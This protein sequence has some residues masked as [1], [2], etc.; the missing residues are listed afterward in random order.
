MKYCVYLLLI[1]SLAVSQ[2][3]SLSSSGGD[4]L[5]ESPFYKIPA[6]MTFEEYRDANRRISVGMMMASIPVPGM[7]HFYADENTKGWI[8][9]GAAGLGVASMI[10]GVLL[11]GDEKWPETDYEVE[12]ID[13]LRY[14]KIPV[15]MEGEQIDYQLKRMEMKEEMSTGGIVLIGFGGVLIAGQLI[16]DWLDGVSTI[17][18]KRDAVRYKYGFGERDAM[19]SPTFGVDD[20][21][22]LALRID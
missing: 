20:S 5:N 7:L 13:G 12:Y 19:L 14:E 21:V 3:L 15:Y 4:V 18:Y 10:T 8:C 17:V 11:S 2:Q 1:V 16:Y 9:V 22:G 6:G